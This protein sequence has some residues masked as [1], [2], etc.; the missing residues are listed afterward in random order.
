MVAFIKRHPLPVY[1]IITFAV[2]WPIYFSLVAVKH[3]WTDAPIPYWIHYLAAFGPTVG[4]L[5]V[6]ASTAGGQGLREL[7]SRI[8]KW[9]VRWGY[10]VFAVFSPIA[11]FLFA[12]LVA[13]LVK[14]EWL[15]LHL[16]GQANYLPYLG[17]GVL[18][19][20]LITFG[21][22]E[23]IGWRGFVLPRLQKSMSVQRATL[24]LA[25]LW[26]LW[27][28][29]AFFYL[30]TFESLGGLIIIPGFI[31]GVLFGAV[32]LTWLYNGTGGSIFMVA[33][34][35]ALFDLV[36]ASEA[37]Q[38]IVPIL[39]TVGV[40]IWALFVANTEKPWGFRFQPKHVL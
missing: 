33:V 10:A 29:P 23:E 21:F 25:L 18:P 5:I 36:T 12:D 38:D 22:G 35:H 40:I 13:R 11:F 30:D 15:D 19:L 27:H 6:T 32:L 28:T 8:I 37:G 4:A 34:W 26:V 1:G 17:W 16:L 20:W 7:W 31:V 2:S 9:R 14:G 39:T 3:G 24:F